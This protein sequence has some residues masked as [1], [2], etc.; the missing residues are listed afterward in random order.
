MLQNSMLRAFLEGNVAYQCQRSPLRQEA[1]GGT[2][3]LVQHTQLFAQLGLSQTRATFPHRSFTN[4]VD[5]THCWRRWGSLLSRAGINDGCIFPAR[6]TVSSNV[7]NTSC[8]VVV[9]LLFDG[10]LGWVSAKRAARN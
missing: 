2:K 5:L 8:A 6:L 7:E 4:S 9:I 10:Q 1:A 3:P